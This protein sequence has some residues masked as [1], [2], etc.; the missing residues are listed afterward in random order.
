MRVLPRCR[1][2]ARPHARAAEG[3]AAAHRVFRIVGVF[4]IHRLIVR[5]LRGRFEY[6][7]RLGRIKATAAPIDPHPGTR[8]TFAAGTGTLGVWGLHGRQLRAMG[9]TTS[10]HLMHDRHIAS[11]QEPTPCW[12]LTPQQQHLRS[13][14]RELAQEVIGPR[15]A[16]VDRDE[17][18]PWANVAALRA[19]GFTG[20]TVPKDLGGAGLTYL[21][22]VLVIEEIAK[23]CTTTARIVVETNMGA[24]S[25]VLAYGSDVQRKL[26]AEFVLEGDKPAICITEPGAGSAATEMTT[27]AQKDGERFVINGS[28]HWITGG[29]V[30]KFHLVFARVFDDDGTELGIGG[31]LAVRDETPGLIVGR[32]EP[33]L[34]IRGMPETEIHFEDMVVEASMAISTPSGW[35]RGFADLMDAYN[36]QRLGAAA[37]SLGIAAGSCNL[38]VAHVKTREQFGRPIAEFQ[39]LQWMIADMATNLEAARS[40]IYRAALSKGPNGRFPD[41]TLTAQA[42]IFTSEKAIRVVSDALQL[43][44]A[45]GYSRRC[46]LERMYRDVRMFTIGGGTAQI[47]RTLVASR[48]LERRLPQTRDGY[49]RESQRRNL[50][51]Q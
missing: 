30:S 22:A 40:L 37:V 6:A 7:S 50:G 12:D 41:P 31:F 19:E 11:S 45:K 24:I 46:P 1:S 14:A 47:L 21:D 44:G 29:G 4:E 27:R 35:R 39:G 5:G 25:A 17:K 32:R 34:G 2:I 42:K 15:A 16:D 20:M 36:S 8:L 13:R 10:D 9:S 26:A 51:N 33:T 38:A 43:F 23:V 18:Y 49:S 28:K 48:V 3:W